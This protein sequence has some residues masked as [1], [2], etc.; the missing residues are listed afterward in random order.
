MRIGLL[1]AS[2]AGLSLMAQ[3][4][5]AQQSVGP[6]DQ[7]KGSFED[8][9]RQF[10]GEDWPTPTDYRNASGA[11]GHRYWQQQV[12]YDI[13]VSL[14]EARRT[15]TGREAVTYT[16]NSPDALGYLWLLLD[17]QNYRRDSLAERSRTYRNSETV[18][19]N[20]IQRIRRF[21]DWEGG[22]NDLRV[23]GPD[24]QAVPFTIVDSMMRIELPRPLA[25][26]QSF[27]FTIDFTLPLPETNV[28]G[29]RSGYECFT[30]AHEDGNCLFL[31]AQWFPRLAVYSDYEGWHNAQFFGSGEF[32]LEFGDYDVS[33]TAPTDHVVAAT[34][35]LTNPDILS[36]EQR[37]RLD[38]S[39][40][41]D[42]PVYIVT[43]QEA[44]AAEAR[45]ARSGTRTWNFSADNVRDFGWA[46][47]RKFIWD[48]M[49]VDQ[50]SAEHPV[51]MAMSFYPKEARP[52]WDAYST[53]SIAHTLD[54][55]NQFAFTYPYPTAQSVNGPVGGM[56]YPMITFNGPRPV[57]ADDGTLTYTERAK[58]G[59][60]GVVIHEVGH[61]YFPMIVN[62]DERQ[63]TWMDE[64][65][66]SFLQYQAQKLW[67]PAF[68]SRGEPRDIVEYMVSEDQVPVMTHSD[69]LL[70]F[71]NNAYAKPATALVILRET[72]LGRELFDRAFREYSQRWAFKRPTPYDFF[73]TMEESSGVDLDWFWRG[74]FY[75][76]DH[77][78][79]A[80]E[81]VTAAALESADPEVR[82][83][84]ARERFAEE[85]VP[86]TITNNAGIE[87]V[88]ERD[89]ATRDFYNETDRFTVTARERRD[90]EAAARKADEERRAAQGFDDNIYRFTF[91]NVGGLVMPVI[92]KL[93]YSDGS[94]ETIRIPA[95]VWR[96]DSHEVVWQHVSSKTLTG[97]EIDPLWE[98]ADADR[99]NNY[100][101]RRID[102]RSL[103]LS[104]APPPGENRM[105]DSDV[106]VSPDST[107]TR[108]RRQ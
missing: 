41:A 8:K 107:A 64:G 31:A 21:Q 20:E 25:T 71:G 36:V 77:V 60:I 96:R 94:N 75:S 53:K 6:I 59:L 78:D 90:A 87:T 13:D 17:Q 37:A 89:P 83:R 68:P 50:Q 1:L 79:I 3:A 32:T 73:R 76:T 26:G 56:E 95:E 40:T 5:A 39:R 11:P 72:V 61:T 58:N 47:S 12:D 91:R 93:T 104:P 81:G 14:D 10:E 100:Y 69:S 43:P 46:S 70:Q 86:T 2:V 97:A 49:G 102:E 42:E 19:V 66:N 101:P 45:P 16:N 33:I 88:I 35:V 67:D 98:T 24:G 103:R 108:V 62:S 92:L 106:E 63:W 9:F 28:V 65:L 55:Y 27:A 74:W 30:K 15:L 18:S 57:R 80:L 22:F 4:T 23:T 29:G 82:A 52:L 54:V 105:R 7:S 38:R 51:V 34:G 85:P 48:A 84:A 44:A 99:S